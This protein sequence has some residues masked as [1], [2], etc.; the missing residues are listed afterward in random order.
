[1]GTRLGVQVQKEED[2]QCQPPS[3][4]QVSWALT[5]DIPTSS[6]G[7][8]LPRKETLRGGAPRRAVE[9]GFGVMLQGR[10]LLG[11][12]NAARAWS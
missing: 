2:W 4:Y 10:G 11:E 9:A 7:R 12:T 3:V 8:R 1:M 6:V 5:C